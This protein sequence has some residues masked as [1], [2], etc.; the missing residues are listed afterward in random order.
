MVRAMMCARFVLPLAVAVSALEITDMIAEK[1]HGPPQPV[2]AVAGA[3]PT[4]QQSGVAAPVAPVVPAVSQ[5]AAYSNGGAVPS[6]QGSVPGQS[7]AAVGSVLGG[8]QPA[9]SVVITAPQPTQ[10]PAGGAGTFGGNVQVN[11]A[12]SGIGQGG[13]GG[14]AGAMA[15]LMTAMTGAANPAMATNMGQKH[16]SSA[17]LTQES[18]EVV[19]GLI[20]AFMHK[21]ALLPGEKACLE[22]NMATV[23][24][25][26][27]GTI[28]DVVQAIKALVEGKGQIQKKNTGGLVSAGID[29]AMK[30][31]SLVTLSTQTVKE[32]VHG[33][34][35]K[36]LNMT[37]HHLINAT[38]LEHRFVVNGVDIAHNLADSII[39]FE[40]KQFRRFG[41][42]IGIALR[43][44]LLSKAMN[45]TA[46]PEGVP[47]EDI[48]QQSTAGLMKGFF[49]QGASV[50]ITDTSHPDIDVVVDLH[51]CIAGNSEFFKELWMAA[52]DL[53]A[54]FSVN[55]QEHGFV[56]G[57]QGLAAQ[58]G[59][60]QPKWSGELMIAMMQFPMALSKC[61]V[62]QQMQDTFMEAIKSL[63][64]IRVQFQFPSTPL[65]G[66]TAT[67]EATE[68]TDKMA[69]AVQAWTNW[70]FE[71]F[72]FEL[73]TLLRELVMLA[74]P[75]KYSIDARGRL[76]RNS[77][78][79]DLSAGKKAGSIPASAVIV[80]GFVAS[81]LV[82]MA[83]VR[84]RKSQPRLL[85]DRMLLVEDG[86]ATSVE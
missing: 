60:G 74:F 12:F 11:N 75:Q 42:D 6:Y 82:A 16:Y 61:G 72:G 58:P 8:G 84:T 68:V 1:P 33:D 3:Y 41:T 73:G 48:I 64:D 51:Q 67:G 24:G 62:N 78:I 66:A 26:I 52:W 81:V 65:T 31:V 71:K 27:I 59:Q 21:V 7:G 37:A 57:L 5:Q 10:Q 56:G 54:Q 40:A 39:A 43:K 47:E 28:T 38:Y 18:T 2:P 30:I 25:D 9:S 23:T 36:L 29:S 85:A 83:A 63:G 79:M 34:A 69:K 20:E 86:E 13:A 70:N 49:V 32:C 77:Q 35:L 80:G 44:L 46:L 14:G 53:I 76:Q 45:G 4:V 22:K 55:A 19:G 50:E 15:S 17:A